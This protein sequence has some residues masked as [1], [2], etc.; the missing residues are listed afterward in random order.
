MATVWRSVSPIR[1]N[2]MTFNYN[3]VADYFNEHPEAQGTLITIGLVIAGKVINHVSTLLE[4]QSSGTELLQQA[5]YLCSILIAAM[6]AIMN[7]EKFKVAFK[8]LL[9]SFKKYE[10]P[11]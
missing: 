5:S 7:W 2:P 1:F 9:K 8:K 10:K 6:T 3:K 11:S 4:I